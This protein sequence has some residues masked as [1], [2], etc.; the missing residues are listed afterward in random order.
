MML[1]LSI[2]DSARGF[3]NIQI[4]MMKKRTSAASLNIMVYGGETLKRG[5]GE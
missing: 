5:G 4:Q 2:E 1:V 3:A